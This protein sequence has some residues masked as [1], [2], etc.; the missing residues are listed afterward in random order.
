M[1]VLSKQS[2]CLLFF[3]VPSLVLSATAFYANHG[4]IYRGRHNAINPLCMETQTSSKTN[5]G[6]STNVAEP[7]SPPTNKIES[8][9]SLEAFCSYIDNAPQDT[10]VA[11]KF[12]GKSCPLCKR[13]A[14][15]YKKMARY[16]STA[17]IQFAEIEK[18][19]HPQLFDTLEITTFPY[20][21]LY[22]NGQ[23]I[24]SHGT[25]SDSMFERIVHNTIQNFLL[26]QPEHWKSF[27]T[28]FAEPIGKA[29]QNY[30]TMRQIRDEEAN[31][32]SP[33]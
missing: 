31:S 14:I 27:L 28:S 20:L 25:E 11:V 21:Q 30:E 3:L 6:G 1:H 15:K 12:Y 23:C 26:M 24:A 19:A 5:S 22:R 33:A 10:L 2:L 7:P 32:R 8:L 18:T 29:T 16:Y 13:V 17:P 9:T 4:A